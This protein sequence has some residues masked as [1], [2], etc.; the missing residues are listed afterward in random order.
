M[1]TEK[2]TLS[3]GLDLQFARDKMEK[4]FHISNL[5]KPPKYDTESYYYYTVIEKDWVQRR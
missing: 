5:F 1:F 4:G 2:R 3:H